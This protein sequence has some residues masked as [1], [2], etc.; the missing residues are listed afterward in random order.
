[1]SDTIQAPQ[2]V[3]GTAA[4]SSC[5]PVEVQQLHE[6]RAIHAAVLDL[7]KRTRRVAILGFAATVKDAPVNDPSWEL[8]AMNGFWRAAKPDFGIDLPEE[9][10]ALWFDT[11]TIEYTRAYGQAAGIEG[12]QEEWLRK[13]HPFPILMLEEYPEFPSSRRYPVEDVIAAQGGRDY[14]TST[15]AYALAL[16]LAQPDVAE[17]GLWGI[18]LAHDSEYADQRPCAEYYLG[19]AEA[20]GIKVTLHE[21]SALLSQRTR[22]G[23]AGDNPLLVEL[24]EGLAIQAVGLEKAIAKSHADM[25]RA[26][27]Q[28]HTDDGAL[29]TV[30]ALLARLEIYERGGRL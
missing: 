13:L 1:M 11:H 27:V 30:R 23:L 28:A 10:Y 8:W 2:H 21:R 16:A 19:R 9:R 15:V 14:F 24:R 3:N 22:Y 26:K 18:D 25:E 5:V 12:Q 4:G 17:V 29:Q 20:L 7:Q 6:L